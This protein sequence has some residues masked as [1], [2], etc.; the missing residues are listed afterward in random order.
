MPIPDEAPVMSAVLLGDDKVV[1][2]NFHSRFVDSEIKNPVE[3]CQ[4]KT[5]L[6]LDFAHTNT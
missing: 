2:I 5:F 4:V 3:R 6:C 1:K